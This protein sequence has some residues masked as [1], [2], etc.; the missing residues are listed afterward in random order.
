MYKTKKEVDAHV[1]TALS[2]LRSETER[3]LRSFTIAKLYYKINEYST[4]EQYLCSYLSVKEDN[5]QA[6]KLLGQCYQRLKKPDKALQSFQRSLQLNSKQPDV[7]T[8]VCQLLLED[9]NLNVNKAKYW[10]ELAESEKVQHDAVFSLRLKLMNKEN[11][12][13]NQVEDLIQKEI[14][15][16][17]NDV[18]L[19]VRLMRNYIEEN[20]VLDAFKYVYNLEMSLQDNFASNS[21]W[22]NIVWLV[23][24]KYE[25]MPNSKKDWEF[26]LLLIICLERQVN[27]SFSLTSGTAT[28]GITETANL[29]FNLDQYLFKATQLSDKLCAQRE[30]VNLFLDHYRGQMLIHAAAL[31]FKREL[32]QNKNKWKETV[33]SV[34]P[35]LLLAFQTD[36]PD[37]REPWMKHSDEQGK[38]LIQLWSRE[39]SFRCAQAGRTLLSC[40][41]VESATN[42]EN[43]TNQI[44]NLLGN[45]PPLW[46]ST[47]E[48]LS[49]IRQ[50][51]SDKQWRRN[52]FALLYCNSDQRVKELSSLLIKSPKLNEP[53][54]ELPTYADVE[55]HEEAAQ[56]LKPQSLQHMVYLCLGNDNLGFVRAKYFSGLNFSTQNLAFCG[57]ESLNQLDMDTF[58]YAATIQAKRA[59][60]VERE[61]F[62]NYNSGN[63]SASGRP[64]ILPY[65][66]LQG[67]L[68]TDEQANWWQA[69]YQV[70]KNLSSD[71]LAELRANLQFG[72]E[73]VRGVNGPKIDM[74]I[75]F[76][77]GQIFVARAQ[78]IVKPVEKAFLEARA[79]NIYKYGLN[80]VK[81]NNKGVLEPFRKYFKYA[82]ANTSVVERE[83]SNAAEDAVSYL[84]SRYFKKA[85]Y[86]DLIDELA[87][88]Q[89]PFAT[90]LQAEA[91]RK[92]DEA[93]KTPKKAKR[94]YLDH[95]SECLNQTLNLLKNTE[96][97]PDHPLNSIIHTELK[98]LQQATMKFIN[99]GSPATG[100]NNSSTY[101]DAEADFYHEVS[102]SGT[103][104]MN[105]SRRETNASALIAMPRNTELENLVK[106]MA[107]TLSFVKEE[108]VDTIKPEMLSMRKEITS[109]KDKITSL[110][111]A[112]K[113]TRIS[114]NPPSRDDASHVL[115]DLYMIEDALQNQLYQ[116][117]AQPPHMSVTGSMFPSVA[118]GPNAPPPSH[119][120]FVATQQT[121]QQ[122]AQQRNSMHLQPN[123]MAAAAAYNSPMFNPNYPMNYYPPSYMLPQPPPPP[124]SAGGILGP[125]NAL[126]MQYMDASLNFSMAP[127]TPLL[128][129]P[130]QE[131]RPSNLYGLLTQPQQPPT[132]PPP[133]PQ[134]SVP[135]SIASLVPPI[136]SHAP[137]NQQM[138][139]TLAPAVS[140]QPAPTTAPIQFNKALNNQPVERGPPAN[141]VITSS[142]P[143]PNLNRPALLA[144]QP[145]L[146]VTIPPHHIKPSLVAS[147]ETS[148]Q[149]PPIQPIASLAANT[150][151]TN[152]IVSG[153]FTG[154]GFGSASSAAPGPLSIT[155]SNSFA[156]SASSATSIFSGSSTTS[157]SSSMPTTSISTTT[158]SFK[159]Q[160]EQ[161]QA[162]AAAAAIESSSGDIIAVLNKTSDSL[163][164]EP[165][166]SGTEADVEY[167][168]RPDFK[169]IIPLPAEIE[170]RTGEEDEDVMFC[171][172]AKLFRFVDKDWKELGIGDIKI[173]KSK[174]GFSRILMRRDQTHKI[175]ANHKITKE[176][177][178][179]T[180]TNEKKGHIWVAN[181]F[182]DEEL[183]TERFFVRFKLPESAQQFYD[184]FKKA[185]KEAEELDRK[186]EASVAIEKSIEEKSVAKQPQ[187]PPFGLAK[188]AVSN[189]ATSTPATKTVADKLPVATQTST[190]PTVAAA[191]SAP[192]GGVSK[193][194]FGGFGVTSTSASSATD[195]NKVE[196]PK[197]TA[198]PFA[199]FTFDKI[200][201]ASNTVSTASATA[202]T[203]NTSNA[204]PFA[205]IF[206][207]LGK[208]GT[209]TSTPFSVGN[210]PT[211]QTI[212]ATSAATPA[213]ILP[214]T[215]G[216]AKPTTALNKSS[217]SDAEDEYV[218]TATFNPVIPLPDLVEVSTGEENE[219]VLF[220][221]RAKLLRFDKEAGEWKDR[222]IG[223]I[224]LLQDKDD[225]NKVRLVMRREQIHK[226][227]C[228]QRIY[229][230]TLFKYAKNSKT[231]LTWAGQDF[232][233]N[234]L[235]TEMLTVRFKLPETCKEFQETVLKAQSNM[236]SEADEVNVRTAAAEKQQMEKQNEKSAG[237]EVAPAKGFGDAFKPKAG[238]WNCS[239]CY[240]SNTGDKQY[241]IACDSPKDDSVPKKDTTNVFLT[242]PPKASFVFGFSPVATGG[243]TAPTQAA[244][245]SF[246]FGKPAATSSILTAVTTK[247]DSAPSSTTSTTTTETSTKTGFGDQFK[248]KAG[249]WTCQGCYL[250][251]AG[252][253]LYCK[254]C[255]A[256]KDDTV[257]KKDSSNDVLALSNPTQK[258]TFGFNAAAA[259]TPAAS[260]ADNNATA[261]PASSSGFVFG[262]TPSEPCKSIFGNLTNP[263]P[264]DSSK[265]FTFTPPTASS[266]TGSN[267][268]SLSKPTFSFSLQ[269]KAM[270][271][272]VKPASS[273][274][275]GE[276]T[277]TFSLDKKD[278]N[279]TLKPKSPGKSGKSPA[280][281]GGGGGDADAAADDDEYQEEENN[282]YFTPVIP[283]PDKIDVK[284][285][286]EDEELLY[287]HR[288]K[289]YRFFEGEWKERGLGD[290]KILR[291]KQ[292]KKLRVV[293]RREQVLKICL[294]HVLN[295]EVEYKPKDDKSWLFVVNDFSE[296]TVE[297]EKFSLRFK[298]KEVAQ[299]FMDA[300]KNAIDGTA[301]AVE[302]VGSISTNTTLNMT[303]YVENEKEIANESASAG[304]SDADK[305]TADKLLL[306]N[307]FFTA[308][309]TCAGC[310]GCDPDKFVFPVVNETFVNEEDS[311]KALK[312]LALP[313]LSLPKIG[314]TGSTN[315]SLLKESALSP[316]VPSPAT[317]TLTTNVSDSTATPKMG[318]SNIFS[319]YGD[320]NS[321]P[322][323][324]G[325]EKTASAFSFTAAMNSGN[326]E[327]ENKAGAPS[328]EFLFGN[329]SSSTGLSGSSLFGS[330]SDKKPVFGQTPS[331]FGNAANSVSKPADST[332]ISESD[333]PKSIFGGIGS[334]IG[335]GSIFGG[336]P[337]FGSASTS[338][339]DGK[340]ASNNDT[341]K[342]IFGSSAI[343][344]TN[345]QGSTSIF[346][347]PSFAGFGNSVNTQS[348]IFGNSNNTN[349]SNINNTNKDGSLFSDI[350]K[351]STAAAPSFADLSKKAGAID[352][353]SLAAKANSTPANKPAQKPGPGEF[354]GLTDQDAFSSFGKSNQNMS[355]D[356]SANDSAKSAEDNENYDPH[357]DPV[358]ALPDEIRV[359]TGEEEET[360]LFGER[361]TL[362]R[363]DANTKEWKERGVGELKIL[364][365]TT[366]Q[367]YRLVMRREQ[368]HKL[369]LNHAVGPDFSFNNMNNNPKSF[370]WATLN[371]A[372]SG[373]GEVE[374]LAVR[375]KNV[376]LANKFKQKLNE[377]IEEAKQREEVA[378]D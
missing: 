207:T 45:N 109:L 136:T 211:F 42:K 346:G 252:D 356:G 295:E 345:S 284:T 193:T 327:V 319:G 5:D 218:P 64:R 3:Q 264:A 342:S 88:I 228:N 106:Q 370:I 276:S 289:L 373:E 320:V 130:P 292:T 87:G 164:S 15:A 233:E 266:A 84:A 52:V 285:G 306:P 158:F 177:I 66:N 155:F 182:A 152:G 186:K 151:T 310:R 365:H 126:P 206:S 336:K 311:K 49:Q 67:N 317:Q 50:T 82:K 340:S 141:V 309:P 337:V 31:I 361:A 10:C 341:T 32:L 75:V 175:C 27:I 170:V 288:A 217:T 163:S 138:V 279:F 308:Q 133:L 35:L 91:Y 69:A 131:G 174:E 234:E 197:S 312:P 364:Q 111:D 85:E 190:F 29:L 363:Y 72:I 76:K 139:G 360:K 237:K 127:S 332:T 173:L 192:S 215:T 25:Q 172:R 256:P 120:P 273:G 220:E 262:S 178:L 19:R 153:G 275:G 46:T 334:S 2:K 179:T 39:G 299:G 14:S 132:V 41:A 223:N 323:G 168:P 79:E 135:M 60:Q 143:L 357:Y 118:N 171:C 33:K 169:P 65:A 315:R 331:I 244:E 24:S 259:A 92:L 73:A 149:Q 227:C 352:F 17:P 282:T 359:S 119:S 189:F 104:A 374:K 302:N 240:I 260:V 250:S 271:G 176:L 28:G 249:S 321:T 23:L 97:N 81:M 226:L 117:P 268:P 376:D 238:S 184:A 59:L 110:E 48:L 196:L 351:E 71:N 371:Y 293:M 147:T 198:S 77:L 225:V 26:W 150:T 377:C 114:S 13:N 180:P 325:N 74:I 232:S 339:F 37:N 291:H 236:S 195:S 116:P 278:F 54:F 61:A 63:R 93:N 335:S 368:I 62:D 200:G 94:M 159:P 199:N 162:Q 86:E 96:T 165:N 4:A 348:S 277:T 128:Q 283:L 129:A 47:D 11:L 369:V 375:F 167:D 272:P 221:H 101:E 219:L 89:L 22:Y 258:F 255:D 205:N 123:A 290:V 204:S 329:N 274:A 242:N 20:K 230:D 34:M 248:P 80:M 270:E 251:N 239:A 95:A 18:Q 98:R 125:R 263:K 366:K 1:R 265:S 161:A 216:D 157:V 355:K 30:L 253:A 124:G 343:S 208:S 224:K 134:L 358:I 112:M 314:N 313:S 154:F 102:L 21:E 294:N 166:K 115:D 322:F 354:I 281:F 326:K 231:A 12:E 212:I 144:Q 58:L 222:G 213:S 83:V 344:T 137:L 183:K 210:L 51:C 57:A 36:V 378:Q 367:T 209:A 99:E 194:L 146:S 38:Q 8:D 247:T 121:Q 142:D 16:R 214:T 324:V 280:K 43:A 235:V 100:H 202:T 372:E 203:T 55:H 304:L 287:V 261:K 78:D 187:Q 68:C 350:A 362:Y 254:A 188:S 286:E 160:I 298:T 56:Y 53:V 330:G 307:E 181:D 140:S 296:G 185:Q 241:C 156:T 303:E 44:N 201:A 105:R 9:V 316:M 40:I 333:K 349:N 297:L 338:I 301:V 148:A 229:K 347:G 103:P 113:R 269:S 107:N 245:S 328:T 6:H 145:T 191:N 318:E 353:A 90:Y 243:V 257:P 70:Y 305:A 108:L 300:V 122:A 7:L 246:T 267:I